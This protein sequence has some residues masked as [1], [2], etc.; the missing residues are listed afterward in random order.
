[1]PRP[2]FNVIA[3][4]DQK[5]QRLERERIEREAEETLSYLVR[6]EDELDWYDELDAWM[7]HLRTSQT[8]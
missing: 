2:R 6:I 8:S 5:R 4:N 3:Y 7:R 1:M